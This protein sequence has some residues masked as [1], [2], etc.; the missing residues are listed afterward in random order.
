MR[1][2]RRV[3]NGLM[4]AGVLATPALSF[5]W[6][7]NGSNREAKSIFELIGGPDLPV[8]TRSDAGTEGNGHGFEGGR[9]FKFGGE[10]HLFMT[11]M[12]G[13]P[14]WTRTRLAHWS[15][16]DRRKW[17]R[18]STLM[19]SSGDFSGTDP[20]ASLWSPMPVYDSAQGRW[21]MTYVAYRSKPNTKDTWYEN[22]EGRIWRAVSTITEFGG[23][24][25]PY[26]DAGI[27]L[28]PGADAA[29]WE[30]LMGVDSFFPYA[31]GDRWLALYGSSPERNGLAEAAALAG[32]WK[33]ISR[34]PVTQ[35]MENPLVTRL[36]DGR[37]VA[38]F[39]GCGTYQRFGYLVSD[40]GL[41]WSKPVIIDIEQE[42]A[43]VKKW[44]G[45]TRTP[46][47]LIQ[48][49][50]DTFTLFF[51]A[52]NKNFYDVP[53]IWAVNDQG[54]FRDYF[55]SVGYVELRLRR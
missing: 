16:G 19:A 43:K 46:L 25:G 11:E 32:P 20:R 10:Y 37:Y 12:I 8:L 5:E 47:G 18:R 49:S 9:A 22:Y 28:E 15:S 38:F 33:R 50:T 29:S 40:D 54:I 1:V 4:A 24:G 48:E 31:V 45:L 27:L 42:P 51:T 17:T 30:G 55:A 13:E 26:E 23:F 39:D 41:N 2:S 36:E 7:S 14:K 3:F 53:G 35:H 21:S 34:T 52:Y 6:G 44:W